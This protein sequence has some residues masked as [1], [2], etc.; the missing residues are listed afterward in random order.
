MSSLRAHVSSGSLTTEKAS[1]PPP[2]TQKLYTQA[3]VSGGSEETHTERKQTASSPHTLPPHSH[4]VCLRVLL[5]T[6]KHPLEKGLHAL[7]QLLLHDLGVCTKQASKQ[8]VRK[9][10]KK[11]QPLSLQHGCMLRTLTRLGRM[12]VWVL[13]NAQLH[14][15]LDSM[16]CLSKHC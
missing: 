9:K 14:E 1:K 12:L 15:S 6:V 3:Q 13:V 4:L 2:P 8:A 11:Q 10:N 7:Q 5:P 16:C